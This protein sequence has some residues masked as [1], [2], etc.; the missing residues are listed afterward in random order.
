MCGFAPK[1]VV[2][3]P[4]T[5]YRIG[6]NRTHWGY[7]CTRHRR[8]F[9]YSLRLQYGPLTRYAKVRVP[10]APGMLGTFSPPPRV[11]DSDI[12]HGTCVTHTGVPG[13]LTSGFLWSR[14]RGKRSRNSW[15]MRNP[16]FCVS[17]KRDIEQI[18]VIWHTIKQPSLMEPK[19]IERYSF[20]WFKTTT[21]TEH[22]NPTKEKTSSLSAYI[23]LTEATAALNP[24]IIQ[25]DCTYFAG[26]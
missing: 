22:N 3:R 5:Q 21:S 8:G 19:Q 18:H 16:Q 4:A 1:S 12:H 7:P 11:R 2:T 17:G 9:V 13:S 6:P 14:W 23:C 24:Q 10:H 25:N 26:W 20:A 15:R